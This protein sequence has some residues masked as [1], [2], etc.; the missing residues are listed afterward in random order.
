MFLDAKENAYRDK[1]QREIEAASADRR[2]AMS[3]KEDLR[4]EL[5]ELLKRDGQEQPESPP[6]DEPSVQSQAALDSQRRP[7]GLKCNHPGGFECNHPG[8]T[9]FP[10]QTQYL[11]K[12][13]SYS[14]IPHLL[15]IQR[16]VARIVLIVNLAPI[17]AFTA[18]TDHT[19][20]PLEAALGAKGAEA[21]RERT[22]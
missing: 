12:Y 18:N 22:T 3:V 21:S 5:Y 6:V 16:K 1:V 13:A 8:C 7:G 9:A 14:M 15:V 17:E 10:F 19:I 2:A 20:V 11:L 4:T